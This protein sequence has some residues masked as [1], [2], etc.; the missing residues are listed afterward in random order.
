MISV[1]EALHA[2]RMHVN[3]LNSKSSVDVEMAHG[4]ILDSD[5]YS[6]CDLPPFRAS[7]KDGYAVIS[8]D[9]KGKRKVLSGIKAGETVSNVIFIILQLLSRNCSIFTMFHIYE[10]I[11]YCD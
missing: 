9:G 11:G 2:I 3:P 6:K 7:I 8:N 1:E 10:F 4:R 5:L